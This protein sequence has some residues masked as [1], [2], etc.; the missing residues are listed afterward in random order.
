[1]PEKPNASPVTA[2]EVAA[3]ARRRRRPVLALLAAGLAIAA[4]LLRA[5]ERRA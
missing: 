4:N 3:P 5:S 1:M 2:A